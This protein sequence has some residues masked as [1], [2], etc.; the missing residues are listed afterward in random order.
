MKLAQALGANALADKDPLPPHLRE[1]LLA[2]DPLF[3]AS[4]WLLA[5]AAV[6][7]VIVALATVQPWGAAVPRRLLLAIAWTLG[8]FMIARSIGG[9][10]FG[11][12][13]DALLLTGVRP[14]P[15]EHAALARTLARWDLLLW[16]PFFLLWGM[17]WATAGWRLGRRG[18]L[19]DNRR[20]F[21]DF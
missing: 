5:G 15:V 21:G 9:V 3:V 4:H 20:N 18:S 1:Q 2:R 16:S 11:F 13:G 6:V 8:I 7:G 17:C 12:V 14:A 10:G 19:A